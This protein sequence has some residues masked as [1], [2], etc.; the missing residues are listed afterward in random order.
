MIQQ[1]H[2]WVYNWKKW[3]CY[4]KENLHLHHSIIHNNRDTETTE[5]SISGWVAKENVMHTHTGILFNHK[6]EILPFVTAQ[7]KLEGIILIEISQTKKDKYFMIS[8]LCTIFR[9]WSHGNRID[10]R[11]PGLEEKREN[12]WRWSNSASF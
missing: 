10:W 7:I 5:V 12:G 2:L 3:N 9:K 11:W 8:L 4:L 1:F 6:K